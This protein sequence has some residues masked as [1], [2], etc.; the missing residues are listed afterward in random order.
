MIASLAGTVVAIDQGVAVLEVGGLSLRVLIPASTAAHLPPAG[1]QTKL[2][3][4]LLVRADA[5]T[6]YGFATAGELEVFVLLLGVSGLGPA[7]ALELLSGS[8]MPARRADLASAVLRPGV[9]GGHSRRQVV[10]GERRHDCG[11]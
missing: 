2:F 8:S 10:A 5:R 6:L 7:K 9:H 4:H 11:A 3:T 1:G